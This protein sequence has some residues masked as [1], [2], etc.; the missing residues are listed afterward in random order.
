MPGFKEKIAYR[1]LKGFN[2]HH[3]H[4]SVK[5][6]TEIRTVGMVYNV[7]EVHWKAIKQMIAFLEERGK[8]VTTLGYFNEKE[9]NHEYTP[10]F[11]HMYFCQEQL[12]FWKL[13][14][15]NT[16]NSFI[17]TEFD[18]LINLDVKAEMVLQAVSTYSRA[19]TRIGLYFDQYQFSQDFM[20]KSSV[21]GPEDLFEH[22]K[23]Y[24]AK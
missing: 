24:I 8:S 9:L 18:Y 5:P 15:I 20:I 7:E 23:Q 4:G 12:S 10:N 11:K 13:P 19:K 3:K 22:I 14:M 2:Q 16:L 17:N 1:K 21:K 6:L